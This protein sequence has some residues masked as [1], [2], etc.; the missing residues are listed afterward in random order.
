MAICHLSETPWL[1]VAA[2]STSDGSAPPDLARIH[3]PSHHR[4]TPHGPRL[5]ARSTLDSGHRGSCRRRSGWSRR[6]SAWRSRSSPTRSPGPRWFCPFRA[7]PLRRRRQV[8][9]SRDWKGPQSGFGRA[10]SSAIVRVRHCRS[11]A[12]VFARARA[13]YAEPSSRDRYLTEPLG[14]PDRTCQ[15]VDPR[16]DAR[17]VFTYQPALM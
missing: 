4:N 16:R 10:R 7:G 1:A 9:P 6:S 17:L 3:Q 5:S 8:W 2:A 12:P 13:D 14:S 15:A 11:S